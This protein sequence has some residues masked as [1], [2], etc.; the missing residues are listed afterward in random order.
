MRL[1]HATKNKNENGQGRR[2]L[3][4]TTPLFSREFD[5]PYRTAR[6][7]KIRMME[8]GIFA[9]PLIPNP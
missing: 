6:R 9:A 1:R 2:A 3:R 7:M 4:P 5:H 8:A